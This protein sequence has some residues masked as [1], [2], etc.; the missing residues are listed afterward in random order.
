[1]N[2]PAKKVKT[3]LDYF[4]IKKLFKVLDAKKWT[5]GKNFM[6]FWADGTAKIAAVDPAKKKSTIGANVNGN[7]RIYT[8]KWNWLNQF[9]SA[10]IKYKELFSS[11]IKNSA[12]TNLIKRKYGT[13]QKPNKIAVPFNEWLVDNLEPAKYLAKI[14]QEQ[15]QY[16]NV[17]PFDLNGGVFNDLVAAINGYNYFVF[18]KGQTIH[19]AS[20]R[21]KKLAESKLKQNHPA[22][23]MVESK[24][25]K[26]HP[27]ILTGIDEKSLKE[28][29]AHL[30][31]ANVKS[32]I[33]ISHVGVYAGDIYEFN[34]SQY[35]ATWDIVGN[36]V[37]L[38]KLDYLVGT[39]DTDDDKDLAITNE[40][41]NIYR[42]KTGNGGD[43]MA[44]TP[45]KL[46]KYPI[47]IPVI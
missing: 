43:F 10:N 5:E 31:K 40:T 39:S 29:E 36:T 17:N 37:E 25:K 45:V 24:S 19:A 16:I 6:K 22:K 44:L 30:N 2:A 9:S 33:Y 14:K 15:L 3:Q 26:S 8:V 35:L 18:Y 12:V 41:Y 42:K 27:D 46:T 13:L 11:R 1:M 34:G 20:Y 32:V 38:S 21:S 28:I 7:L 23:K 4:D 47:V